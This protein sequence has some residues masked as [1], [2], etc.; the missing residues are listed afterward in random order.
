MQNVMV[1]SMQIVIVDRDLMRDGW[2]QGI[3]LDTPRSQH[4]TS[5]ALYRL[6]DFLNNLRVP[7]CK[8][9]GFYS[10]I[11]ASFVLFAFV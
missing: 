7:I 3:C 10:V 2:L 5:L 6:L 9:A 8:L 11:V 1:F 4:D